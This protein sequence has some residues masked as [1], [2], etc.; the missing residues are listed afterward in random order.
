M[1][2]SLPKFYNVDISSQAIILCVI[3]GMIFTYHDG[4][5]AFN[6]LSLYVH[7]IHG[8]G[9]HH[10]YG[11]LYFDDNKVCNGDHGVVIIKFA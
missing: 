5:G 9:V 7:N 3:S 8:Y 2:V 10:V 1:L 11:T 6:N 4:I